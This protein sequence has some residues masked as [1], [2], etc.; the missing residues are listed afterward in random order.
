MSQITP[1]L[2]FG[3]NCREAFEFYKSCFGGE[4]KYNVAGDS[5]MADQMKEEQK[6]QILHAALTSKNLSLFGCDML[7]DGTITTGN[8]VRLCYTGSPEEV[9][10]AF[11]KV[12]VGG[13][14]GTDLHELFFGL[15][16]DLTDKYGFGWMF[17]ADTKVAQA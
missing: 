5:P 14:V 7:M 9:K 15:Y 13:K 11:A 16:G 10:D 4:V 3:G 17:Q 1:Y 12:A 8:Y 6:S 2:T